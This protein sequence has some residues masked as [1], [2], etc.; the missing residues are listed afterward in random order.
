MDVPRINISA[1][2]LAEVCRRWQI[3]ELELFGSVLRDDF[4]ESSDI[5]FLVTFEPGTPWSLLDLARLK[6]EFEDL[7]DR[8]VDLIEKPALQRHHNP[9]LRHSI[10]RESQRIYPAA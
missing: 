4:H 9:W 7:L 5:D 3:T 8:S 6:L 2:K 1:A 10:L